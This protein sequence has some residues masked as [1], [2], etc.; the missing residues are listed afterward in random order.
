MKIETL[1]LLK[2]YQQE[3]SVELRNKIF[4]LNQGL[5]RLAANRWVV[6]SSLDYDDLFQIGSIGLIKA[7]ERFD[8]TKGCNLST[9]AIPY[10]L[11]EI[12]H[13]VRDRE[14][15]MKL[16]RRWQDIRR[17]KTSVALSLGYTVE[18]VERAKSANHHPDSLDKLVSEDFTI[19]DFLGTG[20]SREL[21]EVE[22]AIASIPKKDLELIDLLYFQ[23]MSQ[24]EA[25]KVLGCSALTVS[26]H[27]KKAINALKRQFS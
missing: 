1:N 23:D 17:M 27:K 5:I 12:Q 6:K 20:K 10:I 16:P 21:V 15:L 9:F 26:R 22:D 19:L 18:E 13:F 24:V 14:G 25:A 7:I 3:K 8:P 2:L 11:G 4:I